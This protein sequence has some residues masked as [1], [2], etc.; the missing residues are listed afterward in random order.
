MEKR[1]MSGNDLEIEETERW[2]K[3][4]VEDVDTVELP[5]GHI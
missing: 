1:M 2:F 4:D 5:G 3:E